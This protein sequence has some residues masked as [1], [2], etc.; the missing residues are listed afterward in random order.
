MAVIVFPRTPCKTRRFMA[1]IH[2]NRVVAPGVKYFLKKPYT[3][4]SLLM[5]LRAILDETMP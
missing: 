3:A 1:K 4:N 2:R 5:V